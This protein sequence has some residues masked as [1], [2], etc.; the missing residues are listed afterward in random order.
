MNQSEVF[1]KKRFNNIWG[2]KMYNQVSWYVK[3]VVLLTA[4]KALK[5]IQT[6]DVLNS[7]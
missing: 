7:F 6:I 3:W 4:E 5:N 1:A 2:Q